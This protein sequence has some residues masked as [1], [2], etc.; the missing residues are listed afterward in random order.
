MAVDRSVALLR[1]T[2]LCGNLE[3][4]ALQELARNVTERSYRKG[5]TIVY[6]GDPGDSLFVVAEGLV[7]VFVT[8]DAG[9]EMVLVTLKAPDLFGEV[10]V[11]DE[12]PRCASAEALEATKVIML[13]RSTLLRLL[14]TRPELMEVLM[15][16]LG[17][18]VRRPPHR[19][20]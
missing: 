3:D 9:S 18:L 12:G 1:A 20:A 16:S 13:A 19:V 5:Q 6:Q 15:R 2:L 17:G 8:S 7:K 10:S 11:V 14:E 4:C